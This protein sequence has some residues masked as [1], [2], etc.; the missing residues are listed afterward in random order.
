MALGKQKMKTITK[1]IDKEWLNMIISGKKKF[2]LRAADFE[3]ED[4]DTIRLE[5]WTNDKV[6]KFTGRF[7]EK[8]ATYVRKIDLKSWI[9]RQ[10]EL[11]ENGL[12]II[13]FE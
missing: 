5:E 1:K 9:N 3:I 11:L 6:R 12:Y 8:K 10:P 2:E 7:I 13:Q 4:G